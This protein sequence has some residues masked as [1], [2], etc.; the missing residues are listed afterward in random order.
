M[1][2]ISERVA[3]TVVAPIMHLL[4]PAGHHPVRV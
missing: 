2:L 1:V 3:E 4:A